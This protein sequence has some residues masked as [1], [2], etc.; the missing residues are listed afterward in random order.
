VPAG[1]P[2]LTRRFVLVTLAALAYFVGLG[3]LV[4]VVPLVVERELDGGGVA[5][6]VAVG[7]FSLTA[8]I[9]RPWAGLLGDR[10]GRRLLVV[11][12]SVVLAVVVAGYT[13]AGGLAAL[14]LLRVLTGVGEAAVFVGA[15]T[16][17]Q[18]LAPASRRGE[19]AS[20]FSVAVYGGLA[21]GPALGEAVLDGAGADAAWLVSSGC[22]LAAAVLG[23]WTPPFPPGESGRRVPGRR[24]ALLHASGLGPGFVLG[25]S[26][27]GFAGFTTFVPLYVDEV[28]VSSSGAVFSTFA[29]IVLSVRV[30][31]ARIPDRAGPVR[32]AST[33][34]SLLTLGLGAL[35]VLRSE[36]GLFGGTA[37]FALGTS[38]LYP[39]LMRLVVDATP[40]AE[41]S[42]EVAT[43]SIFFDLSQGLGAPAL[44]VV[45]ALADEPAAFAV[46]ALLQLAALAL[47]R[48]KVAARAEEAAATL[49]A[50]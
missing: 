33:A 38:L 46:G 31:G 21:L 22:C 41:R 24:P 5:V 34:L 14:V 7:A 12:G 42:S 25:L 8:A 19:A 28:G 45:V 17:V 40:T 32:V 26:L 18:D 29:V 36:A 10:S 4:P 2:L 50:A 30:L 39:S 9:L 6:G 16:A 48:L 23:W 11:G 1:P 20:Y 43:F 3:I 13:L 47:L 35:A 27:I 49:A 37:L 44:G 15:A